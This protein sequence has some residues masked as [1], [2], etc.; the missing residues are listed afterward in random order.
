VEDSKREL[1]DQKVFLQ[2]SYEKV[3]ERENKGKTF[4]TIISE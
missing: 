2:N 1:A 4:S 3:E